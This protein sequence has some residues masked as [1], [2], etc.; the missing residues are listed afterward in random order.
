[1][2]KAPNHFLSDGEGENEDKGKERGEEGEDKGRSKRDLNTVV[3]QKTILCVES[4]IAMQRIVMPVTSVS[5]SQ[6]GTL[7]Y[8]LPAFSSFSSAAISLFRFSM[9][10]RSTSRIRSS[11][12]CSSLGTANFSRQL[13]GRGFSKYNP[14]KVRTR[15]STTYIQFGMKDHDATIS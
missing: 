11:N 6:E 9:I 5:Y 14:F 12:A 13:F 8:T 2:K 4:R 7:S 10:P 15:D 1:M 3:T